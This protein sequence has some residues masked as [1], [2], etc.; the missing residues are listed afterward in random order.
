MKTPP[1][2][3]MAQGLPT[4]N[5]LLRVSELPSFVSGCM[6]AESEPGTTLSVHMGSVGGAPKDECGPL[7]AS[8]AAVKLLDG[9]PE[10][11]RV[12]LMLPEVI[13]T[14]AVSKIRTRPQARGPSAALQFARGSPQF[15]R[16]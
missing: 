2:R 12:P 8:S 14:G 5:V 16:F 6:L 15:R 11:V 9:E 4:K 3:P 13:G 10:C 7:S 1:P